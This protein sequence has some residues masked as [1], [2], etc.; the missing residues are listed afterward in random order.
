M[1]GVLFKYWLY[2]ND[3]KLKKDTIVNIVAIIIKITLIIFPMHFPNNL[4]N[5]SNMFSVGS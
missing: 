1:L 4:F 3:I 5:F 2:T